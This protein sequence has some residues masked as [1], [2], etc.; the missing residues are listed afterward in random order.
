[1]RVIRKIL[2]E[3]LCG[4]LM[5]ILQ[6]AFHFNNYKQFNRQPS[7][8]QKLLSLPIPAGFNYKLVYLEPTSAK[9]LHHFLISKEESLQMKCWKTTLITPCTPKSSG[10]LSTQSKSSVKLSSKQAN[11]TKTTIN[12]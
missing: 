5:C 9:H 4:E 8:R 3:V 1:M 6:I 12:K 7:V 11:I 10:K 2:E